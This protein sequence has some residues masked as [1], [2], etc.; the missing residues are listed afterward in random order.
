MKR[1][2][3]LAALAFAMAAP[4]LMAADV[5]PKAEGPT[6]TLGELMSHRPATLST[7]GLIVGSGYG[8]VSQ[9]LVPAVIRAAGKNNTFF[10]TDYFLTNG[11]G[12]MQDVLIGFMPSGVTGVNQPT[13][14][15]QLAANTTYS[16]PD[17]LGSGQGDLNISGVGSLLITAVLPGSSTLDTSGQLY[18]AA[19]IWTQEPGSSGTNSFTEWAVEP[20][21]IHGDS[22]VAVIGARQ[23]S[24]FRAN[25]GLV[26]LDVLNARTWTINIITT[27][28]SAGQT[29]TTIPPLSMGLVA[30][31]SSVDGGSN[32][33]LLLHF[34]PNLTT[35]FPWYAFATSADQ[36]TGDA[37]Y[38]VGVQF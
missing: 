9:L 35:N 26:N 14:R 38:S 28:G 32:G 7:E 2:L 36:T 27:T 31:P 37:W 1:S 34:T 5:L 17:F 33:Y 12:A 16:I 15:Y 8:F 19:R 13:F 21:V 20:G 23:N 11:R 25:Y 18:G 22:L 3:F 29:T 30:V 6:P 24:G 4:M 10:I